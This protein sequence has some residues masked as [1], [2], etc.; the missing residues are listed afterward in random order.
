MIL[1]ERL[2]TAIPG[3]GGYGYSIAVCCAA[4]MLCTHLVW[5]VHVPGAP[6]AS[7]VR[8]L[9]LQNAQLVAVFAEATLRPQCGT[10]CQH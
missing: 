3:H 5:R 7:A 8:K 6:T 4:L 10:R 2:S 1:H 9:Q